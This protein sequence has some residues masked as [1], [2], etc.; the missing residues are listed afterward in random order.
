MVAGVFWG[1]VLVIAYVYV[2]YPLLMWLL[3]RCRRTPPPPPAGDWPPVSLII[4]AFNEERVMEE[5]LVNTLSL[6]YP[7][8]KLEVLVA[9]DGSTDR[10]D[11]IVAGFGPRGVRLL[12]VEGRKGKTA[13]QNAAAT[14]ATGEILVFSDA[15]AM[16]EPDA[17]RRLVLPFARGDVGS[18]EGRR[19]DFA[20]S[21]SATARNELTYRDW[22][23]RIKTWE[24]RVLSCTGATGPLYAVRR[25]LY[26]A[27]DPAMISDFM[28]PILVM[29]RHR[30]RHVF[31]PAAISR[32]SVNG[33]LQ[34]EFQRKVRIMTRCLN[35]LRMAP[36]V[37]NPLRN[38]WF[39]V[40]VLSHRLLRWL[41]PVF[42]AAAFT[43]NVVLLHHPFYRLTLLLQ[44]SFL[45]VAAIG[46]ALDRIGIGPAFLRLPHYF[47]AA[48]LAALEALANC[49]LGRNFV[50]WTT[51]RAPVS[52][53]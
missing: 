23:S 27:L 28:E 46:A 19:A 51:E 1:S 26:I 6:D 39:A 22:E 40:Q 10:T 18:V 14:A 31:E 45:L 11:G 43:A 52:G 7:A 36:D 53:H 16:Y 29:C 13:A 25:S 42:A 5:K 49:I 33:A 41:V 50:T 15:N 20:S 24:S 48:N 21:A 12:R 2:G 17:I 4:A 3:S 32:E 9:S 34:R 38:G 44:V 30:K 47:C 37:L 8:D 35:S